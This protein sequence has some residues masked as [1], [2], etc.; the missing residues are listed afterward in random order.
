M[1]CYKKMCMNV[2]MC[3]NKIWGVHV[4]A[5]CMCVNT[6]V[7]TCKLLLWAM[8][9]QCTVIKRHTHSFQD[10]LTHSH[11]H[12]LTNV[13]THWHVPNS[14]SSTWGIMRAVEPL[15]APVEETLWTRILL[16]STFLELS[17]RLLASCPT[18]HHRKSCFD[19]LLLSVSSPKIWAN[20]IQLTF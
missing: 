10:T 14:T 5:C 3:V 19:I 7:I 12:T 11:S 16:G 8:S 4:W 1:L 15:A 17:T 2:Y 20:G 13:H 18:R 9:L 6:Q